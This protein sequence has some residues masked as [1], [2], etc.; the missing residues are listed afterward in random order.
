MEKKKLTREEIDNI[1]S[2]KF[3]GVEMRKAMP[4]KLPPKELVELAKKLKEEE[5][6]KNQ[7]K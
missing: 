5:Q 4:G 2:Q 6:Q 7:K 1:K 3:S